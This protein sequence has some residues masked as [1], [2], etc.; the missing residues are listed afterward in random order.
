[1]SVERENIEASKSLLTPEEIA[2]LFQ[3][4]RR[5][6]QRFDNPIWDEMTRQLIVQHLR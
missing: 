6:K 2:V 1:M 5:K 4:E 3:G